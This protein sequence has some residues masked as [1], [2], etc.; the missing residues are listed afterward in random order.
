MGARGQRARAAPCAS[1]AHARARAPSAACTTAAAPNSNGGGELR[2]LL[3][4]IV[5]AEPP[6]YQ[7]LIVATAA[8]SSYVAFAFNWHASV[9]KAGVR[10]PLVLCLDDGLKP[11]L[12]PRG[13]VTYTSEH[14]QLPA[15]SAV[16]RYGTNEFALAARLK[17]TLQAAVISAG[18][19]LLFTDVDAPWAADVRPYI[20]I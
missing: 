4:S 19:D 14:V 12:E 16:R 15:A 9:T 10:R 11:R 3:K 13:I 2:A 18:F 5:A 20:P 7:R 6:A 17:L 1:T 8:D